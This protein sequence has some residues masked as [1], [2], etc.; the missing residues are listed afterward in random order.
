MKR[1]EMKKIIN[2]EIESGNHDRAVI[3]RELLIAGAESLSMVTS[4]IAKC[5]KEAGLV[6]VTK[7]GAVKEMT[8]AITD[9]MIEGISTYRELR[10]LAEEL[11][12]KF[13]TSE[14]PTFKAIRDK[15]KAKGMPVPKKAHLGIVKQLTVDYFM[16]AFDNGDDTSI[17]GLAE[18]LIA[19]VEGGGEDATEEMKKKLTIT[20]GTDYTFAYMMFHHIRLEDIN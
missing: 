6:S 3:A 8:A 9:E 18:Y 19:N 17:A 13:D 7:P 4:T 14:T 16:D 10:E 11:M 20:A 1:K 15:M 5:F 2:K 12:D